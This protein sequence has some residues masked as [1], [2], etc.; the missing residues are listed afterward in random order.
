MM[1]WHNKRQH[2]LIVVG[3]HTESAGEVT[4]MVIACIECKPEWLCLGDELQVV[5]NVVQKDDRTLRN[6]NHMPAKMAHPFIRVLEN[7]N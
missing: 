4:A 5:S 6:C 3:L 1:G 2:N 7:P